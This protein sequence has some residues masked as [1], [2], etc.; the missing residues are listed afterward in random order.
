MCLLVGFPLV[1][2]LLLGCYLVVAVVTG[3]SIGCWVVTWLL[4]G[5]CAC[6]WV[7]TG[8]LLGFYLKKASYNP[9]QV[10]CRTWW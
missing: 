6:Y 7:V 3:F 10:S 2:G 1:A 5:C 8:L 9:N 4:L